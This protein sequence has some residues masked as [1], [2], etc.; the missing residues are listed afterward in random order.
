MMFRPPAL[1]K[2]PPPTCLF[3]NQPASV[4]VRI[5]RWGVWTCTQ[6]V[7]DALD[8]FNEESKK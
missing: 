7:D 2:R 8:I 6:H 1:R 4:E 3:C 5:N